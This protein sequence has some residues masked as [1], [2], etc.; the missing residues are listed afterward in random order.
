MVNS[1]VAE[2]DNTVS[3]SARHMTYRRSPLPLQ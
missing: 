1:P 3:L 2:L